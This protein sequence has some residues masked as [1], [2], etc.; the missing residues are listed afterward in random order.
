MPPRGAQPASCRRPQPLSLPLNDLIPH[1]AIRGRS[2][3]LLKPCMARPA[4]LSQ[5][6]AAANAIC[7][8]A[9]YRKPTAAV[10]TSPLHQR[11]APAA[12]AGPLLVAVAVAPAL[13]PLRHL[14]VVGHAVQVAQ[15]V[16]G[17]LDLLLQQQQLADARQLAR[18]LAGGGGGAGGR[19]GAAGRRLRQPAQ[20]ARRAPGRR[21]PRVA[22][23]A[24]QG[25]GCC[26]PQRRAPCARRT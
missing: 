18:V 15:R 5:G 17:G 16:L 20:L 14:K 13:G 11:P 26:A 9:R 3:L 25:P 6:P 10:K 22:E 24:Q 2:A 8:H 12:L 4:A 23:H 1:S 19:G 7:L 21:Q